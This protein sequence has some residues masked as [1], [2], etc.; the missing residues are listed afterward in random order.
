MAF[1][2]I[3]GKAFVPQFKGQR[4]GV[5]IDFDPAAW[6]EA[7]KT[8]TQGTVEATALQ[9]IRDAMEQY[10]P[11][12]S[13]M[14]D[15]L[16]NT[17]QSDQDVARVLSQLM[18][19]YNPVEGRGDRV[20]DSVLV[21]DHMGDAWEEMYGARLEFLDDPQEMIRRTLSHIDAKRAALGL[22]EYDPTQ[23]GQSGDARVEEIEA[24]IAEAPL[25]ERRAVLYG[26]VP[27]S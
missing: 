5:D 24:E 12:G 23:F 19:G 14:A 7:W 8:G 1:D 2:A 9:S 26:Q 27:T 18:G 11:R 17:A 4:T 16:R 3:T 10:R 25:E 13:G 6:Q 21:S 22:S 15:G 20:P